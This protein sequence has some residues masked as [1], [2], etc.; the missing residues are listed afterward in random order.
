MDENADRRR[1]PR[2]ADDS[3]LVTLDTSSN[4][5][6]Y[7]FPHDTTPP[8]LRSAAHIDSMTARIE[9]SQ[10]LDPTVKLDTTRVHV[11][12]LPDSTPVAV[13]GVFT[14]RGFDSVSPPER[15]QA[16]SLRQ[17]QAPTPRDTT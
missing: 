15:A 3:V 11:V 9:F 7:T 6:L 17:L 2:E 16:D 5:A 13:A 10:A 4:V 8:R 12:E 1:W 14:A